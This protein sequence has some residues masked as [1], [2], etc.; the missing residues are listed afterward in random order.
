MSAT[1]SLHCLLYNY[2]NFYLCKSNEVKDRALCWWYNVKK[3]CRLRCCTWKLKLQTGLFPNTTTV[4][5]L[6]IRQNVIRIT[7]SLKTNFLFDTSSPR[8]LLS[9]KFSLCIG[10]IVQRFW[11]YVVWKNEFHFIHIII[12]IFTFWCKKLGDKQIPCILGILAFCHI[13]WYDGV[14]YIILRFTFSTVLKRKYL[15]YS[16][17]SP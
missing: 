8:N 4:A 10:V 5:T 15:L 3:S 2:Y 16:N 7:F 11:Y 12:L 9:Y 6:Y 13:I 14:R 1:Y 17:F